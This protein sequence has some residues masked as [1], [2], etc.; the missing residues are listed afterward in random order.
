MLHET[1]ESH[2]GRPNP[3]V[4]A[5]KV[6]TRLDE[7]TPWLEHGTLCRVS[8]FYDRNRAAFIRATP[9]LQFVVY[10]G[11]NLCVFP[12]IGSLLIFLGGLTQPDDSIWTGKTTLT[13]G[14]FL[15]QH[16]IISGRYI[17]IEAHLDG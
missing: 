15:S 13:M 3:D 14:V 8:L 4:G 5:E 2:P 16:G 12:R 17:D 6:W 10:D 1:N 7:E 9:R 11:A